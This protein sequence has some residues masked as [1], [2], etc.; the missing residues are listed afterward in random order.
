M[1]S[2]F[3]MLEQLCVTASRFAHY[4]VTEQCSSLLKQKNQMGFKL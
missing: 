2:L 3:V 4:T 1:Y